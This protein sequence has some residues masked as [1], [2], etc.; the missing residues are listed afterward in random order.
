V[1]NALSFI[2][3]TNAEIHAWCLYAAISF[4][5]V[6]WLTHVLHGKSSDFGAMTAIKQGVS[7]VSFPYSLVSVFTFADESLLTS[8]SDITKF[9]GIAGIVLVIISLSSLF[10]LEGK[11]RHP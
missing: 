1:I 4:I 3:R 10:R 8:I 11:S 7:G 9:V 6:S 2:P 5:I